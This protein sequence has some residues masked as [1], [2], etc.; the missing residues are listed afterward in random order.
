VIP[1]SKDPYYIML[2]NGDFAPLLGILGGGYYLHNISLP[3]IRK[4]KNPENNAR[5]I[6]IGYFLVF[7]SYTICGAMGYFGFTAKG[8]TDD[9]KYN[10][11][12]SNCLLM[13]S[14]T[15]IMATIIRGCTF[16]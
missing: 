7:L 16:F 8:F 10:G 15:D 4:A 2:F 6:F 14:Q 13:Y 12:E 3:I 5:D 9:P 11:I 1:G